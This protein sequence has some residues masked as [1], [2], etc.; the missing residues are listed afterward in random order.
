MS[1]VNILFVNTEEFLH[2]VSFKSIISC[3]KISANVAVLANIKVTLQF[4]AFFKN[5][6][7]A[8]LRTSEKT[9][10][11]STITICCC[12]MEPS[13]LEREEVLIYNKSC[14]TLR[15]NDEILVRNQPTLPNSI[16]S[17]YSYSSPLKLEF[18]KEIKNN[19]TN[20]ETDRF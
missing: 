13:C 4:T 19:Q 7:A 8:W 16:S 11:F 17:P 3:I 5:H 9:I 6:V 18:V 20:K 14:R 10:R 1:S 12:L 2:P 15:L